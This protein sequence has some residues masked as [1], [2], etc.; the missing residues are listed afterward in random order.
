MQVRRGAGVS[1]EEILGFA[2]LFNDELTLDN[3]NRLSSVPFNLPFH[4][5]AFEYQV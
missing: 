1:N 2:K 3:I 4:F 5:S